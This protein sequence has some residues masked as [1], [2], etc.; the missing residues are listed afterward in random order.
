[1]GMVKSLVVLRDLGKK[2]L[3]AP[4]LLANAHLLLINSALPPGWEPKIALFASGLGNVQNYLYNSFAQTFRIIA[5]QKP[6]SSP[7]AKICG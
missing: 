5:Q 3:F 6:L 4:A 1:M 2:A 7:G